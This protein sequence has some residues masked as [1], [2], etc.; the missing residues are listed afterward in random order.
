MKKALLTI[1]AGLPTLAFAQTPY[2][3]KAK[4]GTIG[5]PSKVF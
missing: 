3:I 1:L 4:V 5:A 2:T